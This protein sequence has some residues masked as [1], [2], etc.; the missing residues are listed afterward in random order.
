MLIFAPLSVF[1]PALADR[2]FGCTLQED[3]DRQDCIGLIEVPDSYGGPR[4]QFPLNSTSLHVLIEA[5]KKQQV[6]GSEYCL[7]SCT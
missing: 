5:F 6:S 7:D 2:L 4:V 1:F 3:R